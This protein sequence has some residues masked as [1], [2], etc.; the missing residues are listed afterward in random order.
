MSAA[1]GLGNGSLMGPLNAMVKIY[2]CNAEIARGEFYDLRS[3]TYGA[4]SRTDIESAQFVEQAELL[5]SCG[6][7][8]YLGGGAAPARGRSTSNQNFS[9]LRILLPR[10]PTLFAKQ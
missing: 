4:D 3:Q 2:H 5:Y 8:D 7:N 9:C 10:Q 6:S 1:L